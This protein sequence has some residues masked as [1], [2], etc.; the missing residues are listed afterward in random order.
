MT[1]IQR[2]E[3]VSKEKARLNK[4]AD[5]LEGA[6]KLMTIY[7]VRFNMESCSHLNEAISAIASHNINHGVLI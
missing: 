2:F 7:K 4:I 6:Q 3:A 5:T 1:M